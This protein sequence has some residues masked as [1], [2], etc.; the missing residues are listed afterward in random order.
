MFGLSLRLKI[1]VSTLFIGIIPL[2]VLFWVTYSRVNILRVDIEKKITPV[3]VN[4]Q[5]ID[6]NNNKIK[7]EFE[8]INVS[9]NQ[10]NT[11]FK[12]LDKKTSSF[13]SQEFKALDSEFKSMLEIRGKVIADLVENSIYS[14]IYEKLRSD[15]RKNDLNIQNKEFKKFLSSLALHDNALN[16]FNKKFSVDENFILP[17]FE[18]YIDES[19]ISA[20]EKMGYKVAI[21]IEGT[22]KLSSFKDKDGKFISI[23]RLSDLTINSA[24]EVIDGRNYFL[25]FRKL[26]DESGF[27]IGRIAVAIDIEDFITANKKRTS[28][29]D[30]LIKEFGA[31]AKSQDETIKKANDTLKSINDNFGEQEKTISLSQDL[32]K[33]SIEDISS[34]NKN[35]INISIFVL[36]FSLLI[37]AFYSL[38]FAS[39]IT[40]PIKIIVERL[41]DIAKGEGDLTKRLLI[42]RNDELGDLARWFD[43]FI[44]KLQKTIRKIG[45][46][47]QLLATSLTELSETAQSL[48]ASSKH[49]S[50]KTSSAVHETS[51]MQSNIDLIVA[52]M[53][54]SAK[55]ASDVAYSSEKMTGAIADITKDYEKTRSIVGESVTKV[56]QT[57]DRV[58]DLGEAAA[59]IDKVTETITEISDQINLLAL[60]ATIESARAGDAGK[61]FAVV[62]NEIKELAKQTAEASHEIKKKIESI[63]TSASSTVSDIEQITEIIN[64]VNS[65]VSHIS[66]ESENQLQTITMISDS[67]TKTSTG[68]A[69]VNEKVLHF[70]SVSSKISSVVL[71]V[72]QSTEDMADKS[73]NMSI[74]SRELNEL[75]NQLYALVGQFKID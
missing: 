60:N 63:Q 73:S 74:A 32:L 56:K 3:S 35:L 50:S 4:L 14:K 47:A 38:Y 27:E 45:E 17:Y 37:I 59:E 44:N 13:I 7:G 43:V 25:T 71:D 36:V 46:N 61:G 58:Q 2:A 30:S 16:D 75:S 19:I 20:I 69:D 39:T 9:I 11:N 1:L 8:P 65:L 51:S 66:R 6:S 68:I 22:M 40:K 28:K 52:A 31:L 34:Y 70:S 33:T 12:E 5:N 48:N 57:S 62:A 21:L 72:S 42:K 41:K 15:Q 49:T 23:S 67:I 53:E 10:T 18:Q 54:A 29:I 26:D 24:Y 64:K 55:N